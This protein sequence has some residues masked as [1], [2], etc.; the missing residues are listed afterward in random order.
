MQLL[1]A[2]HHTIGG[3]NLLQPHGAPE[4]GPFEL[5]VLPST[6]EADATAITKPILGAID[7]SKVALMVRINHLASECMLIRHDLDKM[8]GRMSTE[9][10]SISDVEDPTTYHTAQLTDLQDMVR[11]LQNRADDTEDQ[12]R[13]NNVRVVGLPEGAEGAKSTVFSEQFFKQ[14]LALK[15]LPPTYVVERAHRVPT[16]NRPPPHGAPPR[17]FLVYLLNYRDRDMILAEA[18]KHPKL[19]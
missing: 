14:L 8:R 15:D 5:V 7:A 12:Q 2:L 1:P 4:G 18:R 9:K 3:W 6:P 19:L 13:R 11:A 10:G 17:P 16:G